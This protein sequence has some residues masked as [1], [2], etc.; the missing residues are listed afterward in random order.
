M[1][2]DKNHL[3]IQK[4][5]EKQARKGV[6]PVAVIAGVAAFLVAAVL[7]AANW[8]TLSN[9]LKKS[10]ASPA[11]YYQWAEKRTL[12]NTAKTAAGV[13]AGHCLRLIRGDATG[14]SGEV[15][16]EPQQAAWEFLDRFSFLGTDFS[17]LQNTTISYREY[18]KGNAIQAEI[19]LDLGNQEIVILDMITDREAEALYL[20][21]P[22]ISD[23][24][25]GKNISSLPKVRQS[26]TEKLSGKNVQE[27]TVQYLKTILRY[28]D[29]VEK[30]QEEV[31]QVEG[32]SQNCTRLTVTLGEAALADMTASLSQQMEERDDLELQQLVENIREKISSCA[33]TVLVDKKGVIR[34]RTL[35]A[36]GKDGQSYTVTMLSPHAGNTF[37]LELSLETADKAF[38]VRGTGQEEGDT[39]SGAFSLW[40]QQ[41]AL[42][43]LTAQL[44]L[45]LDAE[46]AVTELTVPDSSKVVFMEDAFDFQKYWSTVDLEEL[47]QRLDAADAPTGAV[48][49]IQRIAA[50]DIWEILFYFL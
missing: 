7:A 37:G 11:E 8:W 15:E 27:N 5:Q 31:L 20:A 47:I 35:E 2:I 44:Q 41:A 14:I 26:V 49:L 25:I 19:G 36:Q 42:A 30:E 39:V 48:K 32:I 38:A 33:M 50:M 9:A 29:K 12:Q 28:L 22:E 45:S 43:K 18:S 6:R 34:G 24:Y 4:S 13:Y 10:F 17:W 21:I 46:D 1:T 23:T 40:Y 3:T 16:I